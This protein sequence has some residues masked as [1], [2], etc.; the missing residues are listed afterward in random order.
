MFS[1]RVCWE[2][3]VCISIVC[4]FP[5][6]W[7]LMGLERVLL[8]WYNSWVTLSSLILEFVGFWNRQI[9][10]S[11]WAKLERN[12]LQGGCPLRREFF[13]LLLPKYWVLMD[14]PFVDCGRT[15]WSVCKDSQIPFSEAKIVRVEATDFINPCTDS[16][17]SVST[18][19][20]LVGSP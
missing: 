9:Y 1:N 3:K 19:Q 14:Y 2:E 17:C 20:R 8:I 5:I 16:P 11:A 12:K 18:E 13:F 6:A 4:P 7:L 15:I 10:Q